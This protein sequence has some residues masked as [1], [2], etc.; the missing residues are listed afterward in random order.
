VYQA[1]GCAKNK[2]S[3]AVMSSTILVLSVGIII[4]VFLGY[5]V[6]ASQ[7]FDD[8]DDHDRWWP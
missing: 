6:V 2:Q 5:V 1:Q 7:V 3:G 4:G 8:H